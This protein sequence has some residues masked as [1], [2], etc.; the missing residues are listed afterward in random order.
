MSPLKTALP[1][2]LP[3]AL[4]LALIGCGTHKNTVLE[5]LEVPEPTR[6]SGAT[7]DDVTDLPSVDATAASTKDESQKVAK[8]LLSDEEPEAAQE[9][10]DEEESRE[11]DSKVG[12]V[13]TAEFLERIPSGRSYQSTTGT[14]A[15]VAGGEG[16]SDRSAA[17]LSKP[18]GKNRPATRAKAAEDLRRQAAPP[19]P[20][21]VAVVAKP[22]PRP[23][24]DPVSATVPVVPESKTED[25]TNYGINGFTLTQQDR[26]STFA[27]DVDT[28]SYTITRRK[29]R[30]GYLPPAAAVRVEEFVNYFPYE[31][32]QPGEGHPFAVDVEA[33][34]SPFNPQNHIVRIGV[35]GKKVHF[36]TR[37][38]VNLTFLVDVSGSMQSQD[39]IGLLK[40]SLRMLTEELDDGDTVALVTYA[41]ATKVVLAPTPISQRGR[42]ISALNGLTA[43]GST[44]MGAGIN[45][46]YEQ[47]E[48]GYRPGAVNRVIVASDGDAN[49]GATSHTQLSAFIAAKAK[50]G[51]TL[52]TLGF[53]N[54]NY[55]DTMMER[56]ANDGDGNYYYIDSL[57]ESRRLFVDQL[58]STLEVIAKDVK[59]QVEFNPDTVL[60]YRLIG[61]ENRDIADKDFRNDAVDAGEIGAGHQVTA[62]YEVALTDDVSAGLGTVR[63]R[64][65]APGPDSPA[66]ERRYDVPS[67][68]IQGRFASASPQFRLQFAAA[69]FAEI[70]RGSPHMNEVSLRMVGDIARGAKRVEYG[71]DTELIELIDRAARLRGEGAVSQR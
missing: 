49:V 25:Y 21:S 30:E 70:L 41:G 67:S 33:A 11:E 23:V 18:R 50:K 35:Q 17:R 13:V 63:V 47:A 57:Q 45:L 10:V 22:A 51:V 34:P 46:A 14:A 36:D 2:V 3:L 15:G 16:R 40:D 31:Y 68:V 69:G 53:G 26:M 64:N 59:L 38:P 4:G 12:E 60:A 29:L 58:S 48:L 5:D 66:V 61:Y 62:L 6:A 42:I 44:A 56:L 43:G 71:E 54:G 37:K 65:K 7:T 8:N 9:P 52:T 1:F 19:P 24:A 27:A 20:P 39:K 28:A 55:K 32:A